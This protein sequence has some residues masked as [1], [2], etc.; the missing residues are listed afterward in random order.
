MIVSTMIAT[1]ANYLERIRTF[2]SVAT[3]ARILVFLAIT[4]KD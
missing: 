1:F 3:S 2:I 4:S